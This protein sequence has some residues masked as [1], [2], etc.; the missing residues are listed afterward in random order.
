MGS[1]IGVTSFSLNW[2]TGIWFFQPIFALLFAAGALRPNYGPWNISFGV[3][4]V[5][6]I[7]IIKWIRTGRHALAADRTDEGIEA[8]A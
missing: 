5:A 7:V 6:I 1:L 2:T 3:P 8:I 4:V